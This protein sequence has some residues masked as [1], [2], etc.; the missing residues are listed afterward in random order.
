V[1]LGT[2][3]VTSMLVRSFSMMLLTMVVTD[4]VAATRTRGKA[5]PEKPSWNARRL[6]GQVNVDDVL[7][8]TVERNPALSVRCRVDSTGGID[9]PYVGRLIVQGLKPAEV[10]KLIANRLKDADISVGPV[11]VAIEAEQKGAR[12]TEPSNLPLQTDGRFAP[13]R[14][15]R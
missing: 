8:I 4:G 1:N 15:R 13:S 11:S 7:R 10:G 6:P 3:H 5:N 2:F 14:A 9:Y 12:L